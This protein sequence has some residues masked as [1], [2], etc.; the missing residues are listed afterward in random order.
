MVDFLAGLG[1][2][3][4]QRDAKADQPS[5]SQHAPLRAPTDAPQ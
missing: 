3:E 1:H 4:E 5:C 2:D